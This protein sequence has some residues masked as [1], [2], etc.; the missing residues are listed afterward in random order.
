M[1]LPRVCQ[2]CSKPFIAIKATQLFD[3]RRCFKRAY[4]L[5]NK[6]KQQSAQL[7]PNFPKKKC[8]FCGT[9][10]TIP[11][12]PIKQVKRFNAWECSNCGVSNM[13][14]WKYQDNPASYQMI[15]NFLKSVKVHSFLLTQPTEL[16]VRASFI[17]IVS[18]EDKNTI[19][20]H[21]VVGSQNIE[22]RQ[23]IKTT[24]SK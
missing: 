8:A 7:V 5:R 22:T 9:L 17:T 4:Y 13:I 21:E 11:Y 10:H 1:K 23:E 19:Y 2:I 15:E 20:R 6:Q 16:T 3:S 14:L 18:G 12:D 24:L